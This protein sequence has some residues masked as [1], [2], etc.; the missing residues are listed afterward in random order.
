MGPTAD[1]GRSEQENKSPV[2]EQRFCG[3][4][5]GCLVRFTDRAIQARENVGKSQG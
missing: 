4:P 2:V 5:V 3:P 1:L